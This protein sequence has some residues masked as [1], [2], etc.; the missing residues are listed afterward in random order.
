MPKKVSNRMEMIAS[1][2]D[3]DE[4]E[5]MVNIVSKEMLSYAN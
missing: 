2:M 3:F 5:K 4:Y 1:F